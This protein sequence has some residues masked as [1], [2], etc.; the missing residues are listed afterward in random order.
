MIKKWL[1]DITPAR[2]I[3]GGF[4]ALILTGALLLMLPFATRDGQG[5]GF[6]DALFTATS[7]TCVTGL[8]V[9]DTAQYWSTFGHVVLLT[10]IQIGGMGVVTMAVAISMLAGRKIG[11]KQRWIMQESISAPQVGGILKMT[12]FIL[13]ASFLMEGVGALL[14]SIRFI[15]KYGL[16]KGLWYA[17]NSNLSN[18]L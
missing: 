12:G 16:L 9:Q 5:A 10:L 1:T 2:V 17:L 13:K 4:A 15:P 14:L 11:L 6:L 8:V 3:L 7:A 18:C